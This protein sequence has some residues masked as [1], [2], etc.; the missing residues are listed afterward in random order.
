MKNHSTSAIL[1]LIGIAF[2]I[3]G[4]IAQADSPAH[5]TTLVASQVQSTV[6]G[7]VVILGI[8][9]VSMS[10]LHRL[11]HIVDAVRGYFYFLF[12][13]LCVASAFAPPSFFLMGAGL[14]HLAAAYYYRRE[15]RQP[16]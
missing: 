7:I 4:E 1:T 10:L 15:M 8:G 5:L 12:G 6:I 16:T 13:S 2:L 9:V 14:L 11:S 3:L